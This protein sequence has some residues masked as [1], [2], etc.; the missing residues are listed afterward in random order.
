MGLGGF[1]V[2]DCGYVFDVET[3]RGEIG[4]EEEGDAVG[5]EGFNGFN[6]LLFVIS[7]CSWLECGMEEGIPVPGSCCHAVPL[8]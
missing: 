7:I 4:G 8:L 2:E 3:T 5:A 6:T 1:V